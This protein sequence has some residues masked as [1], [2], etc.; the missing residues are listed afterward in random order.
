MA[1][2]TKEQ[3]LLE[4]LELLELLKLRKLRKSKIA[5]LATLACELQMALPSLRLGGAISVYSDVTLTISQTFLRL[6]PLITRGLFNGL[7]KLWSSSIE[8]IWAA[9]CLFLTE[10]GPFW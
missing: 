1:Q 8:T 7:T 2:K 3:K 4:L 9:F 5:T 6:R 10:L